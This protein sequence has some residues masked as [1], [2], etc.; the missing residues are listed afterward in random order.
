MQKYTSK[1]T[2]I[3]KNKLPAIFRKIDF[4]MLVDASPNQ[5]PVI[6]DYGAGRYT[7]SIRDFCQSHGVSYCAYDPYN[8]SDPDWDKAKPS[9]IVCSNVLN[10]IDDDKT[11]KQI[12]DYIVH[13]KCPYMITVYEG[14]SSGIGAPSKK[15]CYQ[16][17]TKIDAYKYTEEVVYK[18][19]ITQFQYI[20]YIK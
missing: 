9:L 10:V 5:A 2:S 12:H 14:N 20:K 19:I 18:R 8:G 7:Q 1:N 16:R 3:N 6:L 13:Q 15:D 17:N 4:K 11:V